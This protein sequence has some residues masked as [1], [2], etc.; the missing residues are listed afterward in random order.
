MKITIKKLIRMLINIYFIELVL[1]NLSSLLRI[2]RQI[3][4]KKKKNNKD[5]KEHTIISGIKFISIL[6]L[7]L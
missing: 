6:K 7:L 3:K 2:C 4:D 1:F 5:I